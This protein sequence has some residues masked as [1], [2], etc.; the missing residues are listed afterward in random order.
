MDSRPEWKGMPSVEGKPYC[1]KAQDRVGR[2]IPCF[3]KRNVGYPRADLGH[4]PP[5]PRK[6][7]RSS[8][9][10]VVSTGK[11][12]VEEVEPHPFDCAHGGL[13]QKKVKNGDQVFSD[14]R[15]PPAS[16]KTRKA[17]ILEVAPP[18]VGGRSGDSGCR[19]AQK[20]QI[21]AVVESHVSK[22]ETW[23]TREQTWATRHPA[24]GARE[25]P[26]AKRVKEFG[27]TSRG[28]H[29]SLV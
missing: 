21:A 16:A 3:K 29:E 23:G 4:P 12:I 25:T 15:R 7:W 24:Q 26:T 6:E 14:R 2:G 18:K 10:Q 19:A 27:D 17:G 9:M 20:L 1:S 11:V 13:F 22:N 8:A 5:G 28:H